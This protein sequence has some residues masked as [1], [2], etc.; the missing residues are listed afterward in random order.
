MA[1]VRSKLKQFPEIVQADIDIKTGLAHFQAKPEFDQYVALAHAM[2]EAGGAI[3][4]FHPKFRTPT[5]YYA[6]LGVK[7][8][9]LEKAEQLQQNLDGVPGVR[10]AIIDGERW[11]V[12]EKGLD[13]G[14]LVVFA[15]PNPKLRF[16]LQKA[17]KDAGYILE[18]RD[19]GG[20]HGGGADGMNNKEEWS[21]MNHS[22][23]GLC[24]LFLTAIGVLQLALPRPPS[25]VKYGSVLVWVL[26]FVFLFIRSDRSSWPLGKIGWFEAF[27]DWETAQHRIGQGLVLLIA[28]GDFLRIRSGMKVNPTFSRW[29]ILALGVVGSGMLYTHLHATIDPA[30]YQEVAR[31]NF[32]HILMA[33]ISLLFCLSKFAWETWRFPRKGGQYV[34]LGFL[35]AL[36]VVLTLYVE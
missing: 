24:L 21:E 22:F 35:G 32:Q 27:R 9:D 19:H 17:A 30:H 31:M 20:G 8:R 4:M 10:A 23:A 29:G 14:G 5:A 25:I 36:G 6:M 33:T 13:V 3:Q 7:G 12:N 28:I 11:F 16:N 15:D 18:L 1:A 2:E 34:W 26:L